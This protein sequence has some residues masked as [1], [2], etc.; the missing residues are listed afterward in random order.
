M[1]TVRH[2]KAFTAETLSEL[3]TEIE[4]FLFDSNPYMEKVIID[5]KYTFNDD[6]RCTAMIIY[7]ITGRENRYGSV[8]EH[9]CK[10]GA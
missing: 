5:L 2:V 4:R 10:A 9:Y 8:V 7:E 3:E 1:N 6:G